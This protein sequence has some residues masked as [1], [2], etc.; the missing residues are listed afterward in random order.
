MFTGL[1]EEIGIIK[2]ITSIG[3]GRRITVNAKEITDDIKIDDS[4]AING[5]CQTVVSAAPASFTVEAVEETIAKTTFNAFRAGMEVNLERAI[6]L[7]DRM[8]GHIVQ[9]HGDCVGSVLS[10]EKLSTGIELWIS[11]PGEKSVYVAP[12]GSIT[13]D[14][15]SLTTAR[16]N[17]ASFMASIIPHT[18][19]VTTLRNLRPG[20]KVNLE[21]DIIGKYVFNIMQKRNAPE[22]Q[23]LSPLDIYID[24]PEY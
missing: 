10:V 13:I 2:G 23:R 7:G 17:G 5:V 14:G 16:I 22:G 1:I 8:G 12:Q 20:S 9:G 21:F 19:S 11:F 3:G 24:Q 15:V 6:R 4:V 18:W